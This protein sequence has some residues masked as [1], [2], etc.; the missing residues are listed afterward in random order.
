MDKAVIR[1]VV[2]VVSYLSLGS[3]ERHLVSRGI[4]VVTVDMVHPVG[5]HC[6][7]LDYRY[8]AE[9]AV[10]TLRANGYDDFALMWME[11]TSLPQ[12]VFD[13]RAHDEFAYVLR[14]AVGFRDDRLITVKT[15]SPT[16]LSPVTDAFK[17]WWKSPGRPDAIFFMDDNVCDVACRAISELGIRVPQDLAIITHANMGRD[18][19]FPVDLTRLE[20]DPK[21]VSVEAWRML[22][23]LIPGNEPGKRVE[24]VRPVLREGE[25]LG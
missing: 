14:A 23:Q 7:V 9:M 1:D 22:R 3:I 25:S 13:M 4:P 19:H 6:V 12:Y 17:E 24:Y 16:H 11:N 2:G 15:D 8:M 21:E 20:F 5:E 10:K 18:F